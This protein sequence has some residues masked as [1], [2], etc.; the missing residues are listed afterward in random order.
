MWREEQ[1]QFSRRRHSPRSTTH[2]RKTARRPL[3]FQGSSQSS[4]NDSSSLHGRLLLLL[5]LALP[6]CS[7]RPHR[8]F[9]VGCLSGRGGHG[10]RSAR[11]SWN[12][13]SRFR[14][15]RQRRRPSAWHLGSSS[16]AG[17]IPS[18]SPMASSRPCCW[19]LW[20]GCRWPGPST[21]RLRR[22]AVLTRPWAGYGPLP[23]R[24]VA[25]LSLADQQFFGG[26]RGEFL[27]Q[28]SGLRARA[29][30]PNSCASR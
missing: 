19:N 16:E 24:S 3:V 8:E 28:L 7:P 13:R 30:S 9:A 22:I 17:L 27:A 2:R 25:G 26:Q 10:G 12:P 11:W 5:R 23:S 6:L 4:Y 15:Q 20:L 18:P 1:R 29:T 14:S 21:S